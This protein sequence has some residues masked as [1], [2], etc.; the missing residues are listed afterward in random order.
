MKLPLPALVIEL[1]WD[2]G[3]D[4]AIRQIQENGYPK[5][6]ENYGGEVILVGISYDKKT[7]KHVCEIGSH[8]RN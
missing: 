2:R 4:G 1:K 6:L 3:T 8:S 7:K 5:I